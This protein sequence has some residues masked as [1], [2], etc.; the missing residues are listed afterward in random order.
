MAP[1]GSGKRE[2]T[3]EELM[4]SLGLDLDDL[5]ISED[6]VSTLLDETEGDRSS[7]SNKGSEST[8]STGLGLGQPPART[9]IPSSDAGVKPLRFAKMGSGNMEPQSLSERTS[10]INLSRSTSTSTSTTSTSSDLSTSKTNRSSTSIS[11]SARYSSSSRSTKAMAAEAEAL[12]SSRNFSSKTLKDSIKAGK[13]LNTALRSASTSK[14]QNENVVGKET[15]ED[16][17]ASLGLG[18]LEMTEEEAER[19]LLDGVVPKGLTEEGDRFREAQK[20]GGNKADRAREEVAAREVAQRA[21]DRGHTARA[22]TSSVLTAGSARTDESNGKESIANQEESKEVKE[23]EPQLESEKSLD[24]KVEKTAKEATTLAPSSSEPSTSVLASDLKSAGT[25]SQVKNSDPSSEADTTNIDSQDTVLQPLEKETEALDS[26]ADKDSPSA[27]TLPVESASVEP[28][29]LVSVSSDEGKNSNMQPTTVPDSS[30]TLES[31]DQVTKVEMDEEDAK[32]AETAA[33]VTTKSQPETKLDSQDPINSPPG[34][35]STDE[36]TTSEAPRTVQEQAEESLAST[37]GT[38]T[39]SEGETGEVKSTQGKPESDISTDA[40]LAALVS[41]NGLESVTPKAVTSELQPDEKVGGTEVEIATEEALPSSAS[42]TSISS[43]KEQVGG[44]LPISTSLS[45]LSP[46]RK[47]TLSPI[48]VPT[49]SSRSSSPASEKPTSPSGAPISPSASKALAAS[50]SSSSLVA[51]EREVRRKRSGSGAGSNPTTP[52]SGGRKA[53]DFRRDGPNSPMSPTSRRSNAAS[54]PPMPPLPRSLSNM[55]KSESNSSSI[56]RSNSN[57]N[58][59]NNSISSPIAPTSNPPPS[60]TSPPMS[61]NDKPLKKKRSI[62]LPRFGK[63]DKEKEEKKKSK[64]IES[65]SPV[66]TGGKVGGHQRTISDIL[67]EADAAMNGDLD[68]DEDLGDA[69]MTS[70]EEEPDDGL[71]KAEIEDDEELIVRT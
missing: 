56:S 14:N 30:T 1:L 37:E 57:S 66:S 26:L 46:S 49:E 53:L 40:A 51:G 25:D 50:A 17:F 4:A 52:T 22:S 8:R 42:S 11:P 60:Y 43:S 10:T 32:P 34:S 62:T 44:D 68:L 63:K 31:Q 15:A 58:N 29:G 6:D 2:E 24:E 3:P 71:G 33:E 70:D 18:D 13:D 38:K 16:L 61:P 67:R 64:L 36:F 59:S 23:E 9:Y 48:E 19:F 21:R 20:K 5:D 35:S 55:S 12:A 69:G 54:P 65:S 41:E 47:E 28:S 39:V 45:S 27:S 7:S